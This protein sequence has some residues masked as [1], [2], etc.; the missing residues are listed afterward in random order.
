[1]LATAEWQPRK[2]PRD[3]GAIHAAK[4][5]AGAGAGANAVRLPG[6]VLV[7]LLRLLLGQEGEPLKQVHVL[8]VLE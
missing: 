6:A 8:L 4:A 2:S 3:S 1:V 5:L 7:L